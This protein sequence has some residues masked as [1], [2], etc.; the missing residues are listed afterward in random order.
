[1]SHA[2]ASSGND[3]SFIP[4]GVGDAF[5]NLY[6]SSSLVIDYGGCRLLLDCPHPIRKILKEASIQSGIH[7]DIDTLNAVLIT[8]LHADHCCGLE[9]LGFYSHF[10]IDKTLDLI[11]HEDV[12]TDL[13][14]N[15]LRGTMAPMCDPPDQHRTFEDFFNPIP[16]TAEDTDICYGPFSIACKK[17]LHHVPTTAFKIKAGNRIL[18]YSAD[19][20]FDISLIDWL[21]EA[22]LIVHE[23]NVGKHTPYEKLISLP[24]ELRDRMRLIH[25]PDTFET[26]NSMIEPLI[27]GNIY[28]I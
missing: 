20:S 16:M 22:D 12:L 15:H 2:T 7:M 10:I 13:W 23:T 4:I 28:S 18:G 26:Q 24:K 14:P 3:F 25:Y 5:S 1:M 27:E 8:H 21:S 9:G 11:A 17:T 6:Y 19:T